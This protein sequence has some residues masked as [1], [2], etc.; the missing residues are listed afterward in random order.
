MAHDPKLAESFGFKGDKGV[1]VQETFSNTP[2]TGKL[3]KGDI[4]TEVAG[5]PVDDVQHLRN[6]VAATPPGGEVKF[7]V[8]RDAKFADV[9]VRIGEQPEDLSAV[10][11]RVGRPSAPKGGAVEKNEEKLGLRLADPTDEQIKEFG[12]GDDAKQA[13]LVT[14][15]RPNSPAAK[16]G[17]HA[18]DVII[19]VKGQNVRS[20]DEAVAAIGKQDLSKGIRFS[21]ATPSGSR[22]VFVEP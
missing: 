21:I 10:G 4:I 15:V 16:A 17:L 1:L 3:Q 7:K 8:W 9:T 22:F 12:L 5:K 6:T 18:G 13:A 19:Q 20:A 14:N 2:A 11:A